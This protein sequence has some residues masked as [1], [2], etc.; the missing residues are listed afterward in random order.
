MGMV[1]S[2][3]TASDHILEMLVA[4]LEVEFGR[5]AGEALAHRFLA[6]EECDFLWDARCGERWLGTYYK[7]EDEA[8]E[9]ERVAIW[10]RLDGNWFMGI[11]LVDGEGMPRDTLAHHICTARNS[12]YQAMVDAR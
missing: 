7:L 9:L 8:A 5:G 2:I 6:A 3:G 1:Q 12:A 10:G 11:L 4:G